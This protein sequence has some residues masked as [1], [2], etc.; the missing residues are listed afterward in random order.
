[1]RSSAEHVQV[2]EYANGCVVVAGEPGGDQPLHLFP[3]LRHPLGERDQALLPGGRLGAF[4]LFAGLGLGAPATLLLGGGML[5][6]EAVAFLPPD[7]GTGQQ[8]P[9]RTGGGRTPGCAC[10]VVPA[11]QG[12]VQVGTVAY[13]P[14]QFG[15]LVHRWQCGDPAGELGGGGA[16]RSVTGRGDRSGAAA[17]ASRSSSTRRYS[18]S[19]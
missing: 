4:P 7:G 17:S 13:Q 15:V 5:T 14:L 9:D 19:A 3:G 18:A 1:M 8:L 16:G 12:G 2:D 10:L 11:Q 6:F